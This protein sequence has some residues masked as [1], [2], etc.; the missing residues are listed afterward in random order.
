MRAPESPAPTPKPERHLKAVPSAEEAVT[1][2]TMKPPAM[3]DDQLLQQFNAL[4]ADAKKTNQYL[5]DVLSSI[6]QNQ[7]EIVSGWLE[8]FGKK[9]EDLATDFRAK[10]RPQLEL[11]LK[12][13]SAMKPAETERQ[14]KEFL[15]RAV[16]TMFGKEA[17]AK[18][19]EKAVH[20][21]TFGEEEVPVGAAALE[22]SF[23]EFVSGKLAPE[24][25]YDRVWDQIKEEHPGAIEERLVQ[26]ARL[27]TTEE[28]LKADLMRQTRGL[29]NN[30]R[31]AAKD[32]AS[33]RRALESFYKVAASSATA[34]GKKR[35]AA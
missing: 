1:A 10:V 9:E 5:D 7:P 3:S 11:L 22:G 26:L 28:A 24:V 14:V 33:T 16:E 17:A 19:I 4:A 25:W 15:N 30:L 8:K 34:A 21:E 2:G 13:R 23:R 27:G 20:G 12:L 18:A 35:K 31:M 6:K 32:P 29:L